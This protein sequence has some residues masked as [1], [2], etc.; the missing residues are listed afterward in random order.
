MHCTLVEEETLGFNGV[1]L[2]TTTTT[3]RTR[4]FERKKR[5]AGSRSCYVYSST[6]IIYITLLTASDS[7]SK[8]CQKKGHSLIAIVRQ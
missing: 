2:R 7:I 8:K 1:C 5:N 4:N 6:G 3:V